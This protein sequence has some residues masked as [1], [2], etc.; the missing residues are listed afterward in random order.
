MTAITDAATSEDRVLSADEVQK[1]E[2]LESELQAV[3]KT[4]EVFAR[5]AAYKS[6]IVGFPAVIRP[7]PKGDAALEFA[8]GQYLRTGIPNADIAQLF[9]QTKGT[10]SAGG[11]AVPDT[12]RSKITERRKAF[13]GIRSLAEVITTADGRLLAWP[14]NDNTANTT[15]DIAAE[16]AATAAGADLTFGEVTLSAYKYTS[17]GTGNLPVKVSVEL[18]QDAEF[19][20]GAFVAKALGTRI[21]RK[22]ALD[23]GRGTGSGQPLGLFNGTAGA[24]ATASGSIPTYAKLN[25]LVHALDPEYRQNASFVMNDAMVALVENIL[26]GNNRPIFVPS[27]N[28]I[29]DA[30]S[31]PTLLGYP[32]VTD[33][34]GKDLA[35]DQQGI[36]FGDINAAYIVRDV[37]DVQV[38]VNPYAVTGYVV[39]DAWARMD[40]KVQDTNA[41]VTMEGLT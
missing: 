10:D 25:S 37:K 21:A 41:F 11:Y 15:A 7:A 9:A 30:V 13:G 3:N 28:G 34:A 22:Q 6:P 23:L 12:F 38:L 29:S 1:Y 31:R 4:G 16:G 14:S 33:Q 2:A 20:V 35:N 8:F 40:A 18:L 36:V 27:L 19:D 17:A 39:Y 32:L 24:I 26:D 5:Q